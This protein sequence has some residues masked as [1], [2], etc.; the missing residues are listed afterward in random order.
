MRAL[1]AGRS[2]DAAAAA[3]RAFALGTEAGDPTAAAAYLV[4]RWAVALEWGTDDDLVGVADECDAAASDGAASPAWRAMAAVALARAGQDEL[5]AEELR[6]VMAGGLG[7]LRRDPGRLHPL[8]CLAEAAWIV[9]DAA[10]ASAVAG[11]LEPLAESC[12][13]VQ[14][15]LVWRGS[16]ARFYG[17]AVA[18]TGRWDDAE[19]HLGAALAV[20]RR[21]DAHALAARTRMEQAAVLRARRR[22]GDRRR[23]AE[24]ERA[25][26]EAARRLGMARLAGEAREAT[27]AQSRP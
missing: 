8:A 19:R 3:A 7:K 9:G 25:A 2:A 23:A 27:G 22:R 11:L 6:R 1:V 13:V 20:H 15:G 18:T 5:A 21:G 12:V 14:R 26:V 16:V 4:Q 24:A 10:A 17:L